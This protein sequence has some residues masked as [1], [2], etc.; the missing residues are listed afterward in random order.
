[1]DLKQ[2]TNP[3]AD[4]E[5]P[6]RK[7]RFLA[8]RAAPKKTYSTGAFLF[9]AP[10]VIVLLAVGIF[11]L[12]FAVWNS[13]HEFILSRARIY[14]L[15][16]QPF[17][18]FQNYLGLLN[19][20]GFRESLFRTFVFLLINLPIQLV[21]GLFLALLLH[22]AGH[23]WLKNICRVSLVI[24]LA[25]TLAVV[26]LMGRLMF[27]SSFGV[28]NYAV[29]AAISFFRSIGPLLHHGLLAMDAILRACVT[30][31]PYACT[32]GNRRGRQA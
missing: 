23:E 27:N 3:S 21:L 31:Q 8:T 11:P 28:V 22:K 5:K 13:L 18:W 19:D 20:A 10:A 32:A 9:L 16:G 2:A 4:P 24:P 29:A 25:T 12:L 17:L 1:M 7:P 14:A 6:S 30:L 26:G 15:H